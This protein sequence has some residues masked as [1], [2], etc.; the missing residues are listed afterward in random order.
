MD[1]LRIKVCGMTDVSN[2]EDLCSLSPDYLGYIF[3]SRSLRYVG[4]DPDPDLF[5]IVPSSIRKTAVFVNEKYE[6]IVEIAR[7]Y[8]IDHIQLH[9][10]ESPEMCRLL[11][12]SGRTIIKAIPGDQLENDMLI[13]KYAAVSDYLLLDT[14]V[15]TYG[16]SGKKFDWSKLSGL[17][18]PID[19]FLSGGIAVEDAAKIKAL[20]YE[21]L[22][23][24]DINSRFETE[25]GIKN[26]EL[27]SLFIKRIRNE[28]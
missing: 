8:E 21:N 1:K 12:S 7:K 18:A 9:G 23:A 16:G 14:P 26:P 27:V 28:K 13:N 22:F 5:Q 20:S 17:K 3:Y 15:I 2:V 11:R 24:V 10:M 6:R 19:F 4:D 25:P